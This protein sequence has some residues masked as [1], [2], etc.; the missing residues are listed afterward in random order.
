MTYRVVNNQELPGNSSSYQFEGELY[1]G[2]NVSFFLNATP[3]GRGPKLHKHPYEEVF[4]VQAGELVFSV[5]DEIITATAGQ[6]VIVP[7]ET[8]HK[9]VNHTAQLTHHVDIH[10]SKRMSTTWLEE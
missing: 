4:I 9:F 7:A 10:V 6:I 5:G 1:G 3:P 8:P 2:A